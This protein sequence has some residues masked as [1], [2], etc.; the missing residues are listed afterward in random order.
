MGCFQAGTK[1]LISTNYNAA[2]IP[3]PLPHPSEPFRSHHAMSE[4]GDGP[5][6]CPAFTL[7]QHRCSSTRPAPTEPS[8]EAELHLEN[9]FS[10]H[11]DGCSAAQLCGTHR[12][13]ELQ[14]GDRHSRCRWVSREN[15]R[16]K[17]VLC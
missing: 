1:L 17:L 8:G 15:Q 2:T 6:A 16:H 12:A 4:D 3:H 14:S 5:R 11:T 9:P 10:P 13:H 7:Q